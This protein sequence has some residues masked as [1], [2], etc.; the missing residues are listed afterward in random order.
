MMG[1]KPEA[2]LASINLHEVLDLGLILWALL[3]ITDTLF[4]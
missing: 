4:G 2:E 3:V 1:F